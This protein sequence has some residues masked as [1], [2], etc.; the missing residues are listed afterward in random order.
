MNL[1]ILIDRE[2]VP[3]ELRFLRSP[4]KDWRILDVFVFLG[5]TWFLGTFNQILQ[6][7]GMV[8]SVCPRRSIPFILLVSFCLIPDIH[9]NFSNQFR[10]FLT[11]NYGAGV[12]R[13][14]NRED[15]GPGGSFGG[16]ETH[17]PRTPTR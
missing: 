3:F 13:E 10:N 2:P 16:G 7:L 8:A 15:M 12:E 9:A 14:L 4:N 6:N 11:Q 1:T 17:T 5:T